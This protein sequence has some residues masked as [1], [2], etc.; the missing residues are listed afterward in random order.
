MACLQT[1]AWV[2]AQ[3]VIWD[4]A[5]VHKRELVPMA[6]FPFLEQSQAWVFAHTKAPRAVFSNEL[7]QWESDDV[8]SMCY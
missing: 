7:F 1:H 2:F 4:P 8:D 3:A 5:E 6:C